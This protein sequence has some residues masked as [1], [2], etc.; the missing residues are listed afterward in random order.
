M[1]AEPSSA[2]ATLLLVAVGAALLFLPLVLLVGA[3]FLALKILLKPRT[4][5]YRRSGYYAFD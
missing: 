4:P 5:V 3:P 1:P 2:S